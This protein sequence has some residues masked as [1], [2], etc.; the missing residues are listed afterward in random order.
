MYDVTMQTCPATA[1]G[2]LPRSSCCL[3]C[4]CRAGSMYRRRPTPP[5]SRGEGTAQHAA[6]T[7]AWQKT[8]PHH[9]LP[10]RDAQERERSSS[11]PDRAGCVAPCALHVAVGCTQPQHPSAW[12][13]VHAAPGAPVLLELLQCSFAHPIVAVCNC[14]HFVQFQS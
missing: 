7:A 2:Q 12:T 3:V 11:W 14:S 6:A 10:K 9:D 4:P 5:L 8:R 1:Y 13:K